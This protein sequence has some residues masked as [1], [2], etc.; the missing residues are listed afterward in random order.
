MTLSFKNRLALLYLAAT[1]ALVGLLLASIFLLVQHRV[2]AD[3]DGLLMYEAIKHTT[4]V[5]PTGADGGI[6]FLNKA[7]MTEREHREADANPV[8]IQ[9]VSLNGTVTDRSPNL[10]EGYLAL[11]T[12]QEISKP[13]NATLGGQRIRQVQVPVTFGGREAGYII[14]AVSSENAERLVAALRM[15]LLIVLPLVLAVLFV[16]TRFL[17]GRGIQPVTDIIAK[18]NNITSH[19]INERIPLPAQQDELHDL[20]NAINSLLSRVHEGIAREKQF[21]ADAAHELRTP[22]AVLK[23]TFEVLLRRPREAEEYAAKIQE[24]IGEIDRLTTITE[25]LLAIARME[26]SS[27]GKTAPAS[28]DLVA[29]ARDI[30]GRFEPSAAQKEI[31]LHF[32]HCDTLP[33]NANAEMLEMVIENLLSNAIKYAGHG[34]TVTVAV[35]REDGSPFLRVQDTGIGIAPADFDKIFDPFYR[36]KANSAK[37]AGLGLSIVKKACQTLGANLFIV[38]ELG[39]GTTITVSFSPSQEHYGQS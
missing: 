37:G 1:G 16:L 35:G 10:K 15:Y 23:G 22:L 20:A 21:T 7:E 33:L 31:R 8:F 32:H 24:G 36:V 28:S 14:T 6:A 34:A 30:V 27:H 25:Q 5:G 39:E 29:V 9:V 4:E 11:V 3:I 2:F 38:S 13:H 19:N 12:A 26:H 18:A 17:A